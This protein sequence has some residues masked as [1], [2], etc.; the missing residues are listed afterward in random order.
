MKIKERT[1]KDI[2]IVEPSG[3]VDF[4]NSSAMRERFD[5]LTKQKRKTILVNLVK[6]TYIDSS[7]LATL[8]E[9]MQKMNN[10]KAAKIE[11][12]IHKVV[13]EDDHKL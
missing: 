13:S 10:Y 5:N 12:V 1:E 11:H 7:G 3:E 2:V 6:V 9:L 4:Y 8:I